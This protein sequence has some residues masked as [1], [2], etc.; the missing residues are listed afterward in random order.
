MCRTSHTSS[1]DLLHVWKA[2]RRWVL[3][4][5]REGFLAF[6]IQ[7]SFDTFQ[8]DGVDV[9]GHCEIMS[10]KSPV[11]N[12]LPVNF[13]FDVRFRVLLYAHPFLTSTVVNQEYGLFVP[14]DY[15]SEPFE[16]AL[17]GGQGSMDI[18]SRE[19]LIIRQF[20]RYSSAV[21]CNFS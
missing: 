1:T 3:S 10:E 13:S 16:M 6:P 9:G 18:Y 12:F 20:V 4:C 19:S 21:P 15:V 5:R 2:T 7:R 8:L 14:L 11:D 17:S